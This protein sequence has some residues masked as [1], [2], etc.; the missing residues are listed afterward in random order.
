MMS[1]AEFIK[2]LA[3]LDKPDLKELTSNPDLF[4]EDALSDIAPSKS[5]ASTFLRIVPF[6]VI[7]LILKPCDTPN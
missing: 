3:K 4:P 5:D 2:I 7:T 6:G 1:V